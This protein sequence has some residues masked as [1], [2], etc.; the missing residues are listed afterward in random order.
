MIKKN[1]QNV[2]KNKN[3]QLKKEF[4]RNIEIAKFRL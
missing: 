4:S 3:F 2:N 1:T